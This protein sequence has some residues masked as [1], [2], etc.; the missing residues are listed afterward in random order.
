MDREFQPGVFADH[1]SLLFQRWEMF[2]NIWL[3]VDRILSSGVE[4][5]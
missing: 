2:W 4:L 3:V 1:L 5:R